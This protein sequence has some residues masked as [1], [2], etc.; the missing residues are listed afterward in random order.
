VLESIGRILPAKE[1][2][3]RAG[4]ISRWTEARMRENGE[5][6]PCVRLDGRSY[7]YP[8]RLFEEWLRS[9]LINSIPSK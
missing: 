3:V 7:G 2:R 5:G 6:P 9:R 8:E 1:M 4:G